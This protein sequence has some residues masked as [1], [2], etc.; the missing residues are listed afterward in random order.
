MVT[1]VCLRLVLLH[2]IG[3]FSCFSHSLEEI[4]GTFHFLSLLSV[5]CEENSFYCIVVRLG[6][7]G[8]W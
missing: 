7:T 2:L 1:L 8:P 3:L 4:D 6:F 5:E